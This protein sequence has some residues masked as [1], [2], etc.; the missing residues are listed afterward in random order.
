MFPL[1]RV[2]EQARSDRGAVTGRGA[3]GLRSGAV[4]RGP[5]RGGG[6]AGG[7]AEPTGRGAAG[8]GL[9]PHAEGPAA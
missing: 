5:A 4:P 6:G 1:R 2:V 9:P 8:R 7:P 3:G